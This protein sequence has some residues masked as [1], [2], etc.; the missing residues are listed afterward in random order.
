M[1]FD[2]FVALG[3]FLFVVASILFRVSVL[4]LCFG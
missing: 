1:H 2:V 3:L 4:I